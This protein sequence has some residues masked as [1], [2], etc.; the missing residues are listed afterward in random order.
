MVVAEDLYSDGGSLLLRRGT[1]LT[2]PVILRLRNQST[3]GS[4]SRTVPVLVPSDVR[5][6]PS[7][8]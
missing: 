4:L 7:Q 2:T 1:V 5:V 6:L 8:D 3:H